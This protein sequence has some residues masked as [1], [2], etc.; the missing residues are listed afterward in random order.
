MDGASNYVISKTRMSFLL[1]EHALKTY[2]DNVVVVPTDAD[3]LKKYKV[4]MVKAKR[5]I[6]NGVKENVVCHIASRGTSKE[7]WDVLSTMYQGSSDQQN[8][9]LEKKIEICSNAKGGACGSIPH[10]ASGDPR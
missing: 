1:Y 9:Y 5:M 7:M 10:K 8:M 3:S 4:E 6:L 2:V